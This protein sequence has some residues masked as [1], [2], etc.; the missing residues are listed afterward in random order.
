MKYY[1]NNGVND[2]GKVP[3]DIPP[4]NGDTL[5]EINTRMQEDDPAIRDEL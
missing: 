5:I 2:N 4:A 3:N 1:G